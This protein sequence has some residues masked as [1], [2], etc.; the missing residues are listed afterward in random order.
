MD[1]TLLQLLSFSNVILAVAIFALV[2]VQ[3]KSVELFFE[4]VL[5]K[6][7][8]KSDIWTELL[9]PVGPLATGGLL[10]IIP[11][12]PVPELFQEGL[13]AKFIFG[14]GLGLLS[15]LLYRIIKKVLAAKAGPS[16]NKDIYT[17]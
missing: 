17:Q 10:T 12:V 5:K 6:D 16:D 7:L 4:H 11:G 1:D 14:V 9:V 13:G 3:R 15:G 8:T 2:F